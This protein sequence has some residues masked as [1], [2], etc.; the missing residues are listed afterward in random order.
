MNDLDNGLTLFEYAE[1]KISNG[2]I[3]IVPS[4]S[5]KPTDDGVE[6]WTHSTRKAYK[7]LH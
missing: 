4:V 6:R 2:S 7:I 1:Q 5:D 3:L